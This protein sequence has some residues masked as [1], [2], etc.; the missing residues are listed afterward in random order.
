MNQDCKQWLRQ[1]RRKE[2]ETNARPAVIQ[3]DVNFNSRGKLFR[4]S[5]KKNVIQLPGNG[6]LT[7]A[8]PA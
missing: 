4:L 8:L 5:V 6:K 2:S 3:L 1:E 7:R